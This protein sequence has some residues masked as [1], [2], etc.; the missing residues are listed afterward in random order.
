MMLLSHLILYFAEQVA[1]FSYI[2]VLEMKWFSFGLKVNIIG[3]R[4]NPKC[5][6]LFAIVKSC[7]VYFAANYL[8]N[9]WLPKFAVIIQISLSLLLG[10]DYSSGVHGF[11]TVSRLIILHV[12]FIFYFCFLFFV[13]VCVNLCDVTFKCCMDCTLLTL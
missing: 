13:C 9:V 1:L 12:C 4:H 7:W 5:A 6:E 3:L 10:S 2:C 11:G 8:F